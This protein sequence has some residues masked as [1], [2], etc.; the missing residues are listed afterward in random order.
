MRASE[1]TNMEVSS[2]LDVSTWAGLPPVVQVILATGLVAVLV[3][4]A[5]AVFM[6]GLGKSR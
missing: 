5:M 3:I 1:E 4:M 6:K 2:V